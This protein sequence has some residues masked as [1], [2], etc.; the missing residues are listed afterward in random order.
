MLKVSFLVMLIGVFSLI[1]GVLIYL[2]G[3][4]QIGS[5]HTLYENITQSQS[6]LRF[7][8]TTSADLMRF[9]SNQSSY[10]VFYIVAG[11]ILCLNSVMLRVET[12][13]RYK[14]ALCIQPALIILFLFTYYPLV[15]L[16]RT[17]FTNWNLMRETYEFVGFKN[18]NWLIYGSGSS[19]FMESLRI[20][21]VYTLWETGISLLGG[22]LLALLFSGLKRTHRIM[23]ALI[24]LPGHLMITSCAAVFLL[25]LSSPYGIINDCL[26]IFRIHGPN[27][28]HQ[29]STAMTSVLALSAWR[30]LGYGMMIYV[31]A[32]QSIPANY[33]EAA[34]IEGADAV[35]S[36]RHVTLPTLKQSI[37]Y[38][39]TVSLASGMMVFQSVDVMTGGGPYDATKV[40]SLWIYSLAFE[41][42]EINRASAVSVLYYLLLTILTLIILYQ[43]LK[44]TDENQ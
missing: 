3:N 8:K 15:E 19:Y 9:I 39:L 43:S 32:M 2:L 44:T 37:F 41:D 13:E 18:Y 27:W 4:L 38:L 5:I 30:S 24:T 10:A 36:F 31:S 23:R 25:M 22:M 6:I 11:L 17:S 35:H 29:A 40:A 42:Y 1:F 33:Y 14:D 20:T 21:G 28:V 16:V 7:F 34:K 12:W 26:S